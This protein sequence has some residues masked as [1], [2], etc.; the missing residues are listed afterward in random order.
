MHACFGFH[1]KNDRKFAGFTREDA[2]E[3]LNVSTRT[4]ADYEQ[5]VTLPPDY[6][7]E[8]MMRLYNSPRLG[9][10]WLR[11]NT[12]GCRLLPELPNVDLSQAASKLSVAAKK[13]VDI[14]F[15]LL[16]I[17]ADNVIEAHEE[18]THTKGTKIINEYIAHGLHFTMAKGK[19]TA[20][21]V[22]R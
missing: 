15:D 18:E 4:L 13:T 3:Q 8:E 10:I 6:T 21:T 1:A 7:V 14:H 12:I 16:D 11:S 5:G 22:L 9:F 17:A 19:S 2:A 20:S